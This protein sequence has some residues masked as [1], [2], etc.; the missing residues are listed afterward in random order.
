MY[1]DDLAINDPD[2]T[3]TWGNQNSR[4]VPRFIAKILYIDVMVELQKRK[5]IG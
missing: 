4:S 1:M 3:C 5:N 2:K